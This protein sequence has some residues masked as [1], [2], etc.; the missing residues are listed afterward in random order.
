MQ[1]LHWAALALQCRGLTAELSRLAAIQWKEFSA[2]RSVPWSICSLLTVT[3]TGSAL[4]RVSLEN[5]RRMIK[6]RGRDCRAKEASVD[7]AAATD[8]S[9]LGGI[10]FST[11]CLPDWY[12]KLH[13]IGQTYLVQ[14]SSPDKKAAITVSTFGFRWKITAASSS[15]VLIK[16][17]LKQ[18]RPDFCSQIHNDL[19]WLKM[20]TPSSWKLWTEVVTFVPF[21]LRLEKKQK[22]LSAIPKYL[23]FYLAEV[24]KKTHF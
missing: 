14:R 3:K 5:Q 16:D 11:G 12:V 22:K 13:W 10:T 18:L 21:C 1:L 20:Q 4:L 6:K 7:A 17:G 19:W 15:L 8:Y 9:E 2:F 23:N 24:G